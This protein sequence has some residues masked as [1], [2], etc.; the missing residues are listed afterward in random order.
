MTGYSFRNYQVST[1]AAHVE[2]QGRTA[3][4]VKWIDE[5][6]ASLREIIYVTRHDREI[7]NERCRGDQL[8][9][10]MFRMW[11]AQTSPE[12]SGVVIDRKRRL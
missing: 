8:V 2:V 11:D 3:P 4:L 12:L 10:C 6:H 9:E 7:V 5:F 1:E